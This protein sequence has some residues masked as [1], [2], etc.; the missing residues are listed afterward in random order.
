M[1]DGKIA[2]YQKMLAVYLQPAIKKIVGGDFLA[3]AFMIP[4]ILK[5]NIF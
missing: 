3:N 5:M 4:N 2:Y 1:Y